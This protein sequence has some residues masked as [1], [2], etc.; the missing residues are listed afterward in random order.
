M[1]ECA[2]KKVTSF[3]LILF[4][5]LG[6]LCST[7]AAP[8]QALASISGCSQ[9]SRSMEMTGCEHPHYLCGF[10]PARNLFFSGALS[11]ARLSDSLK[12]VLDLA[13]DA[14]SIDVSSNLAPPAARQW[15]KV[16]LAE[17]GKVSIHLFNS[18]LNL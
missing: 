12:N 16:S 1:M 2:S 4:F 7:V 14:P 8:G 6:V 5:A 17:P 10:D 3:V 11:S 9:N 18:T 15:K 13:L